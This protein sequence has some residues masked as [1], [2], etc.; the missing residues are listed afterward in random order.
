ME[1]DLK[2]Y[3]A[4]IPIVL[5]NVVMVVWCLIDW[6]KRKNFKLLDKKVWIFIILFVQLFGPLAYLLAGRG[7]GND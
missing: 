2:F 4:I 1:V 7:D 3:A 5:L 6:S